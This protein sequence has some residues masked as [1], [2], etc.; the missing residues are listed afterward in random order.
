MY[1]SAAFFLISSAFLS[2]SFSDFVTFA[3][4]SLG[5]VSGGAASAGGGA[6]TGNF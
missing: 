5:S 3:C 4:F 2:A 1:A 6:Y